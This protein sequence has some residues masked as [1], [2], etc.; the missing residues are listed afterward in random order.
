MSVE[1]IFEICGIELCNTNVV[2]IILYWPDSSK[3][4]D[5]F[6]EQLEKLLKLLDKKDKS[7]FIILGG[8]FNVDYLVN[9]KHKRQLSNLM[10]SYNYRQHVKEPTRITENTSTC[11]DLI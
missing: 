7:K 3:G 10:V 8:D 2:L 9:T 6:Y 5:I 4:R 1:S 11:L